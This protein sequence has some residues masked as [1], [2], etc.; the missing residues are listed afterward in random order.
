[1]SNLSTANGDDHPEAAKK[2]LEDAYTLFVH[3][4]Y[5]GAGY[6]AGYVVECSL[7][8]VILLGR[9]NVLKYGHN[10]NKL[11]A[12]AINLASIATAQTARYMPLRTPGHGMYAGST[13]WRETLRYRPES[14][15]SDQDAESWIQEAENVFLSTVAKM[16]KDGVL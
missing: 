3:H 1:M 2:H 15:V 11:S 14:T 13:G 9:Q 16:W 6:L 10:L 8:S 12:E 7:K 4:R 5:D